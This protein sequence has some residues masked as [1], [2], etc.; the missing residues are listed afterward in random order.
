MSTVLC[1]F[2]MSTSLAAASITI[3]WFSTTRATKRKSSFI[4]SDNPTQTSFCSSPPPPRLVRVV[5]PS[6][7]E[8]FVS[9]RQSAEIFSFSY[10]RSD[11][12]HFFVGLSSPIHR[13]ASCTR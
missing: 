12:D 1:L 4:A 10:K 13:R 8:W 11:R 6:H 7:A 5:S 2:S 3:P 9:K